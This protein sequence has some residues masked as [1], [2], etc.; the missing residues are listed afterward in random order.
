M[1]DYRD[2]KSAHARAA[3]GSSPPELVVQ[4]KAIACELP[5]ARALPLSRFSCADVAREAL[6][7]GI[8]ANISDAT[9]WR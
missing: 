8:V 1:N 3:P 7:S 5:A 4:I 9:V 2:S 6:R